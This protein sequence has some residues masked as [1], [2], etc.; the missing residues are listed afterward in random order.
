MNPEGK[1]GR[2][3]PDICGNADGETGFIVRVDG[4]NEVIGGTSAVAPL[5]AG[6]VAVLNSGRTQP[7]GFITPKLYALASSAGALR[8]ITEGDNGVNQVEGYKAKA[9]WDPCTGLG[10]PNG[11]NLLASL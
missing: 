11:A 10:S 7:V 9:G 6:L 5:W 3:V 2:G 1:M 4:S 8:D